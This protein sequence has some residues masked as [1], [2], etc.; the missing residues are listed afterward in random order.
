MAPGSTG[1]N[2]GHDVFLSYSRGD[3][4]AVEELALRLQEN[5][6]EVWLDT[7]NLIPGELWQPVIEEALASCKSCAV[8]IGPSGQSPWQNE[9]MRAAIDRRVATSDFRVI[10]VLLP[11][12]ERGKRG[13]LPAFLAN[14]TWVEFSESLDDEGAFYRLEC[15]VRGREPGPVR[16]A[17]LDSAP[18]GCPYRGLLCFDV[19]DAPFFFGRE[20]SV[21]WLLDD[22]RPRPVVAASRFVAI[23]G[24]SG[25]GK[26]SL[27]RA[28]LVAALGAGGVAGGEAWPVAITRPG[29]EPLENLADDLVLVP[30]LGDVVGRRELTGELRA[31]PHA[32]HRTVRRALRATPQAR[33]VVLVDQFEELFTEGAPERDRRALVDNLHYAATI[34]GGQT[35]VV[36]TLRA[37][38][39]GHLAEYPQLHTLVSDHQHAVGR[40]SE[41]ELRRAIE[42]PAERAGGELEPGLV[43]L[44]LDDVADQAGALPLLQHALR[45]LWAHPRGRRL[46]VDAYKKLGRLEGALNQTAEEVYGSF[47]KELRKTCR[48]VLLR[49]V[50]PVEIGE[51]VSRR[52]DFE[53]LVPAGG[54]ARRVEDVIARLTDEEARLLTA[55]GDEP[56]RHRFVE[57]SHEALL[58]SWKRLK[59]WIEDS[60]DDI[61]I[62]QRLHAAANEWDKNGRDPS[63]LYHRARL[64]QA[65]A[66][67]EA[68]PGDVYP[69]E[70]EFLDA[71]LAERRAAERRRRLRVLALAATS[72]VALVAAVVAWTMR[73]QAVAAR[74]EVEDQL[75]LT[76][77][78][79]L[80]AQAE[81]VGGSHP[82]RGLLLALEAL[83]LADE[84]GRPRMPAAESA[85]R[86]NL[87]RCE[88]TPVGPP[89][90]RVLDAAVSESVV[91]VASKVREE[92]QTL[93]VREY[94]LPEGELD[95]LAFP[96]RGKTLL[97]YEAPPADGGASGQIM[98][99]ALSGG[100][101]WLAAKPQNR[102]VLLWDLDAEPPS[103][104]PWPGT[105]KPLDHLI[106]AGEE[107]LTLVAR[108]VDG[109]KRVLDLASDPPRE[110]D[111]QPKGWRCFFNIPDLWVLQGYVS[112]IVGARG[113]WADGWL[114]T[115]GERYPARLRDQRSV[116]RQPPEPPVLP[117]EGLPGMSA[118]FTVRA[119]SPDG[120]WVA[121]IGAGET[122]ADKT[123]R[124]WDLSTHQ[125]LRRH[126][127]TE[128]VLAFDPQGRW[129]AAGSGADGVRLYDLTRPEETRDT[130]VVTGE[131]EGV[132]ALAFGELRLVVGRRDGAVTLRDLREPRR[133]PILL[134]VLDA[135]VTAAAFSENG[136]RLAVG[137]A[138]GFLWLWDLD[139]M[140]LETSAFQEGIF[141]GE[142]EGRI[143]SLVVEPGA[144]VA[145]GTRFPLDLCELKKLACRAAGRNLS[146][147]E[148]RREL[149]DLP[150]RETCPDLGSP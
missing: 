111:E 48:R 43:E 36:V 33:L 122:G 42:L 3:R 40:M 90:E 10:P 146:A 5:G 78:G 54:E 84:A 80:A 66:W 149:G 77:V 82:Q 7:W 39:S 147:D 116:R 64:T 88:G 53:E 131:D 94:E 142:Y 1:P 15:G 121:A 126:R 17:R 51:H 144:V 119:A 106:F 27:A 150:Y 55:Q 114:V 136:R 124:L 23:V 58:R 52:V 41:D 47:D 44:L 81:A 87:G 37:D 67:A 75:R 19:A 11:G 49:L 92:L 79:R 12:A 148:W 34:A 101:R 137:D 108:D 113:D 65:E 32:L 8:V 103:R 46:T 62:Q 85:V 104:R 130:P 38:F 127:G 141:L 145:G 102:E 72:V 109:G 140:D 112:N 97:T 68:H 138:E 134:G 128:F 28:G 86:R 123:V 139:V 30:E 35:V 99:A 70:E 117:G 63:Y 4:Y 133:E 59:G 125:D 14:V 129:L 2:D 98:D 24:P 96:A 107:C 57:I 6:L 31:D 115:W 45:Q 50:R 73:E 110:L 29:G 13:R 74:R 135:A 118:S 56:A 100:G 20:A 143:R 21:E 22:L 25:S 71:A 95:P 120:R 91:R 26:S 105:V 76:R 61:R 69:L 132:S 83:R 16:G 93:F 60:Q 89:G 9:E 18:G